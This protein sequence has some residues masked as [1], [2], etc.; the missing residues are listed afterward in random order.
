VRSRAK[1]TRRLVAILKL[2][3]R[4]SEWQLIQLRQREH[5][6]EGREAYLVEALSD[7]KMLTGLSTEAIA[8]QLNTT[9]VN[10]GAVQ[11]LVE[12]RLEQLRVESRR[13]RHME[14][15]AKSVGGAERREAEKRLLDELTDAL[16]GRLAG[17]ARF[18]P[19]RSNTRVEPE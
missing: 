2:Q 19:E 11:L 16:T 17:K 10:A 7:G 3:Y 14:R 12:D 15:T 5:E 8:R 18:N 6:L 4:I 1:K 9:S 13:L